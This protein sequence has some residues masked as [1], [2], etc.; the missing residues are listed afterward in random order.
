MGLSRY[1][2]QPRTCGISPL[3]TD[4]P[5]P[6]RPANV[7]DRSE[8]GLGRTLGSAPGP[9]RSWLGAYSPRRGARAEAITLVDT[10]VARQPAPRMP[11][12]CGSRKS[13]SCRG[14]LQ[15][16]GY[17]TVGPRQ[18]CFYYTTDAARISFQRGPAFSRGVPCPQAGA[19]IS[20]YDAATSSPRA[21]Q[22]LTGRVSKGNC[23]RTVATRLLSRRPE[24]RWSRALA[25]EDVHP[26]GPRGTTRGANHDLRA[27]YCNTDS[28]GI[29]GN[30]VGALEL[31]WLA[32]T[33]GRLS[34]HVDRSS[35]RV[36]ERDS[37]QPKSC[38]RSYSRTVP[39]SPSTHAREGHSTYGRIK[40]C[41]S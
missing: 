23:A 34:E 1:P 40:S 10:V 4:K 30:R 16:D 7:V 15:I 37:V 32:P 9:G 27:G 39:K 20:F 6:P 28:E 17:R 24:L 25:L 19:L 22:R 31:G 26:A 21:M 29:T 11:F 8:L 35:A 13:F 18:F 12:M 33:N 2:Q 3:Q 5:A 14:K 41:S 36:V 38:R